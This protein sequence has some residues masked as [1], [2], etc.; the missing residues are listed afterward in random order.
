MADQYTIQWTLRVFIPALPYG[1]VNRHEPSYEVTPRL[2]NFHIEFL[3]LPF[4]TGWSNRLHD[5]SSHVF[6]V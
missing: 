5:F 1:Y 6:T 2:L 3:L 4:R